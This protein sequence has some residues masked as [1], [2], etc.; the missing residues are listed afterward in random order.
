M[1]KALWRAFVDGLVNNDEKVASS[2]NTPNSTLECKNHDTLFLT[3]MAKINT[4]PI[5]DQIGWKIIPFGAS[6]TYIAHRRRYPPHPQ[7]I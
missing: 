5:Y 1:L 4:K 2:K 7:D 6:H 3:E